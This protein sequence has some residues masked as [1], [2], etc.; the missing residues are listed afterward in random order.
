MK[1]IL[2]TL[3]AKYVHTNL[4]LQYLKAAAGDKDILIEEFT[5]NETKERILS[6]LYHLQPDILAFSCYI[7]NI[8]K[9]LSIC[10]SLKKILPQSVIIL[11]GPEVSYETEKLLAQCPFIDFLVIGEGEK[12]FSALL[13]LLEQQ[14]KD[15]S[16]LAGLAWRKNSTFFVQKVD[17]KIDWTTNPSPFKGHLDNYYHGKNLYYETARGCPFNCSYCLSGHQGRKVSFLPLER[18]KKELN[19]LAKSGAKQIK[20][21]DRTF[22]CNKKRA[23]EI[24]QYILSLPKGPNYHF[25]I[26]ADLLDEE[27]IAFLAT[28]PE[29]LFNFE[30]GIQTVQL[31][32]MQAIYRKSNI[33]KAFTMIRKLLEKTK[34]RVYL[35]LIVGLPYE[36]YS[37]FEISFNQV[38]ALKPHKLQMGFLKILKGSKIKEELALYEYQYTDYPPYEILCNKF[39][40]YE[41]ITILKKV[42]HIVDRYYNSEK[43]L[44]S[45]EYLRQK[46]YFF[47][48]FTLFYD[49]S[50]FWQRKNLF[51][52]AISL[53]ECFSQLAAFVQESA[54]Q[55]AENFREVLRF[56]Y[57]LHGKYGNLPS[58]CEKVYNKKD[59]EKHNQILAQPN[60]REKYLPHLNYL[61]HKDIIN[62]T[63][64]ENFFLDVTDKN[65][66]EKNVN[67]LFDYSKK[68]SLKTK[69]QII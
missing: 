16:S 11:G 10:S 13:N 55:I 67:I 26:S 22:N 42:E 28:V 25:E 3:N 20:F 37:L 34:I 54:P 17:I 62:L 32:T 35:D 51:T 12:T 24:W 8:E 29:G 36:N 7:W 63:H 40:S 58:W 65:F 57:L 53:E 18:V 19:L 6:V 38:M 45:L 2:T 49:L 64:S 46:C 27:T 44:Y 60:F 47:S 52:R 4:A 39:L 61:S 31:E 30:I 9:T 68:N 43:F 5:I 23:L 48:L 50:Q 56:D 59:K 14:E 41:E 15:F 33:N 1:T 21:V 66:V 69:Y